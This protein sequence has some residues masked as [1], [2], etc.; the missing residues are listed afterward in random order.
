MYRPIFS[1]RFRLLALCLGLLAIFGSSSLLL[2]YLIERNQEEQEAQAEQYRRF[3]IIQRVLEAVT[4]DARHG[5]NVNI[6][7]IQKNPELEAKARQL[8][9][10]SHNDV[11]VE[12]ARLRSFDPES[13]GIIEVAQRELPQISE[14]AAR[15]LVAG[16]TDQAQVAELQKRV[17][18]IEETV[19]AATRRERDRADRIQQEARERASLAIR[20]A[21]AMIFLAE[22]IGIALVLLVVRSIIRPLRI[23]TEAI[24]QVNVGQLEL[25]LPPISGDEFGQ[26]ALALRQFRDGAEKLRRLAYQDPLTGL[27]NRA[28]LEESLR[29]ALAPPHPP[30]E[31]L[32][33]YYFD[34]DNFRS[35]NDRLGHKAGDAYLCEAATRLQRF[36]PVGSELFRYGGDKFIA[37]V[38][39]AVAGGATE[40]RL[41]QIAETVLRGLAEPHRFGSHLL[42]MSVSIG[43]AVSPGDGKT[44]ESLINSAEAA[45]HA[46][47]RSGR[48]NA[49][50]ADGQLTG[51]LRRQL[52]L[53]GEIQRGLEQNEFEV[54]YQP[55]VDVESRQVSGAEALVRWR[56]PERGLLL[57][58]EFIQVAESEGLINALG[59]RCLRIAHAQ[60]RQWRAQGHQFRVSV[61]V[62]ARQV[63]DCKILEPLEALRREDADAAQ[64]IDLELTESVLFDS[65]EN[66]RRALEEIKKF[67]YRLGMDDFGT[68]YSSFSYLQRLPID[69]IKIDRQFVAEIGGSR[70]AEAI[71]SAML[72]LARSLDM[73][74]IAEGVE[75][76]LQMRRLLKQGCRVQQG[77]LFSPALPA[78]EF[79][80]WTEAYEL[81]RL[82][83][84]G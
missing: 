42:H 82:V 2:G 6:A 32:A 17:N 83:V 7:I 24:R 46:A 16:K 66:T 21:V 60:L 29:I 44:S 35:V 20:I 1:V 56:H 43:I 26:V 19:R 31:P 13:A 68:G 75:T 78:A 22:I 54:F 53:A 49:R 37:L 15:N 10:Q 67:G 57:P 14:Q 47:K 63:Q 77:F 74:V 27:G 9:E 30:E 39:D 38:D 50:F 12:L 59:E 4:V 52:A 70:Q 3:G 80:R 48:N 58:G 45:G 5:S 23:T 11:W 69:K 34:L 33:L 76:P 65:S 71:I 79:M 84:S 25:D 41:R 73:D 18:T 61:N 40:L 28:Q 55:M 8:E 81:G 62:S 36:L 64:M 51:M 72:A